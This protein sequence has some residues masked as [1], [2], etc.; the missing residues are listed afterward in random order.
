M[1]RYVIVPLSD[2]SSVPVADETLPDTEGAL[3]VGWVAGGGVT[4][5]D[6]GGVGAGPE[7]GSVVGSLVVGPE[8]VGAGV[9]AGV[10][11]RGTPGHP[12]SGAAA[13]APHWQHI[14]SSA[15]PKKAVELP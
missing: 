15:D 9:G 14:S 12:I 13:S 10:G 2:S 3:A 11:A 1:M 6:G 4:G 5:V 7:G 8:V